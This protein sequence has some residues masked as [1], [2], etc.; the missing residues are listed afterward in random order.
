MSNIFDNSNRPARET[1][2]GWFKF[3]NVGDKVG[4]K[5][6][7]MFNVAAQGVF[8][9]QRGF[10]LEQEGGVRVNVGIKKYPSY[11][12]R[13]DNLQVGDELGIEFEKEVPA[14]KAGLNAT[15]VM[16]IFTKLNG[17]RVQGAMC[18]DVR[19]SGGVDDEGDEPGTTANDYDSFTASMPVASPSAPA[20]TLTTLN[21][22]SQFAAIRALAKSKGLVTE[23]MSDE[24]ANE[25]IRT[26]VNMPLL[27][28]NMTKIIIALTGYVKS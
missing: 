27:E 8:K 12:E 13:T 1:A 20:P 19:N 9:E 28:E 21:N 25:A 14:K 7:D 16:A 23:D 4:G 11:L 22:N 17:P 26:F 10:T 2:S 18:K 24:T 5:I 3:V 6:V 15:K